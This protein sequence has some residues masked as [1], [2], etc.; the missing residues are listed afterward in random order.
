MTLT[1]AVLLA[2]AGL[3]AG[4]INSV[5]GG[6]SLVSFPMLLAIGT[7]A[8]TANATNLI[9]V[10]PGYVGGTVGYWPQLAGQSARVRR[11]GVAVMAG[12][13][14]GS[15]VLL[16][17]P[18]SAFDAVVPFCVLGACG[19]LAAQPRLARARAAQAGHDERSPTLVLV[20]FLGGIYGGFFGAGLGIM[21]LALLTVFVEDDLH[22]LNALKG[23]LSLLVSLAAAVL[24]GVFGPVDWVACAIIA[25]A[26][27]VGGRLGVGIARRLTPQ[28]LRYTVAGYGTVVAVVLLAQ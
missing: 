19:L 24:I 26:S 9:A 16:L 23:V 21:L 5:A 15:V 4:A 3:A 6:G 10:T 13:V 2:V 22:R 18:A 20:L 1:H 17:S 7:P 12:A 11:L 25:A 27:L 14:V 28:A 8:L